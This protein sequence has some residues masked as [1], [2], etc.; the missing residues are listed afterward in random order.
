MDYSIQ[1]R[2]EYQLA[3]SLGVDT[4]QEDLAI[5]DGLYSIILE[6]HS[7]KETN[8]KILLATY[9]GDVRDSYT[10]ASVVI[11]TSCSLLHVPY[12]IRNEIKLSSDILKYLSCC[13]VMLIL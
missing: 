10:K 8:V 7:D 5:F 6:N 1:R 12:T 13:S 11:S 4:N 9:F 2:K 3:K